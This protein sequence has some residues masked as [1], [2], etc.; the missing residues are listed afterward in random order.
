MRLAC[1][2]FQATDTPSIYIILLVLD[3][4][5]GNTKA[6]QCY[7]IRTYIVCVDLLVD[8]QLSTFI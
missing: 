3:G 7:V 4:K 5:R 8:I 1:W 6:P 2:I